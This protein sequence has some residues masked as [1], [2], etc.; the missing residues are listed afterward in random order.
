MSSCT[1]GGPANYCMFDGTETSIGWRVH[2]VSVAAPAVC[3]VYVFSSSRRQQRCTDR[4]MYFRV[5]KAVDQTSMDGEENCALSPLLPVLSSGIT[6]HQRLP[7][8]SQ[9]AICRN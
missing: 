8:M 5:Q 3:H 2:Q 1:Q 6:C 7:S 9:Y 4:E